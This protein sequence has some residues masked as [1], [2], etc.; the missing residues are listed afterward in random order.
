ML[1]VH[2][3]FSVFMACAKATEGREIIG[4]E[5][6]GLAVGP[7]ISVVTA[8]DG[9]ELPVVIEVDIVPVVL[10]VAVEARRLDAASSVLIV[11]VG[12]VTADTILVVGRMENQ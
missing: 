11:I 9:E 3:E 2:L 1:I 4:L 8:K 5:V 10:V 12:L 6:T 7:R